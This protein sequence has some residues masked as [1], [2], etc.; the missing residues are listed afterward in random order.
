MKKIGGPKNENISKSNNGRRSDCLLS[1]GR[2][3][4]APPFEGLTTYCR[5]RQGILD[6]LLGL[7]NVEGPK[8][9][10]ISKSA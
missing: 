3:S 10:A 1:F 9:E 8:N 7:K 2:F 6:N 4:V 5:G